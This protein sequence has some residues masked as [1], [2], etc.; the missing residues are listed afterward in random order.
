MQLVVLAY[1]VNFDPNPGVIPGIGTLQDVTNGAGAWAIAILM[2][3]AVVGVIMWVVGKVASNA[4][5]TVSAIG[6]FI[7]GGGGAF[8]LGALPRFINWGLALGQGL[9]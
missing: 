1:Q 3:I 5:V 8:I 6:V 2:L 4:L 7:I 9:H